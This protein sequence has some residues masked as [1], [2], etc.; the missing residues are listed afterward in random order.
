MQD[1]RVVDSDQLVHGCIRLDQD[2]K[3]AKIALDA[4]KAELQSRGINIMENQNIKFV[5]FYGYNGAVSITD[6]MTLETLN[7]DKLKALLG[8][9]LIKQLVKESTETKYKYDAKLEKA[10]KAIFTGDYTFECSLS[11]FLDQMSIKPDD[12][13]KKLL[14]KKLKGDYK[15]DK[16]T[17]L[18]VLGYMERGQDDRE[19]EAPDFDVELWFIYKIKNGELIKAYLPEDNL[20]ETIDK[21]KKCIIVET[22]TAIT[23]DYDKED[24]N[25]EL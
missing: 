13:Q 3:E 10:L 17:L 7:M 18:T 1:L 14:L 25:D 22:K 23:I 12:K 15:Q 24:K 6:S 11:E 21:I 4:F 5:K 16:A 2:I 8:E 20:E 9:G 19:I